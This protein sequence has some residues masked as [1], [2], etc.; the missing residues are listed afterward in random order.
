[1]AGRQSSRTFTEVELEFMQVLWSRGDVTT[2]DVQAALRKQG[3]D[4]ADG[5]IRKI[6][7]ILKRKGH[8][9]RRKEGRGF[10]YSAKVPKAQADRSMV[11]DLMERA[12]G[13]SAT[14]MVASLLDTRALHKKE[15]EE[16][17]RLIAESESEG[18]K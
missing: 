10:V 4:L 5:S 17:K 11:M 8:V 14:L 15:M 18:R 12:F 16:I 9:E 7:S 2:E 13:G 3:R 6:L 1:M